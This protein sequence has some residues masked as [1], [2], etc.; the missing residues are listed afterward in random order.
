MG[1]TP[2][3]LQAK[4]GVRY[5][6][7]A[8]VN[9]VDDEDGTLIPLRRGDCWAPVIELATGKICDWPKGVT[10]DVHYK[11]C[12]DGRYVLLDEDMNILRD[13]EGY[14]PAMLGPGGHGDYVIMSIGD[15]GAIANWRA[16]LSYFD[17]ER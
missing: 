11:V 17:G 6:E 13:I 16:D 9:G 3:Y 7:D 1:K 8:A 4:C 14:V 12:D 10:S 5:W 2:T 15:D